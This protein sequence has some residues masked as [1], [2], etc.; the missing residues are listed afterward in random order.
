[1]N[2]TYV[3]ISGEQTACKYLIKKGYK[4]IST[5]ARIA[6]VEVDIVS[7]CP[8]KLLLK[9]LKA[10]YKSGK[11]LKTSYLAE[12]KNLQDTLVF[13]EVKARS[14]ESYGMPAEAVNWHKQN[15]IRRFA[16]TFI[17]SNKKYQN[18]P[19]RFDIISVL[20][21]QIEHIENAF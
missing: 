12:R 8:K 20:N 1:M 17:A 19:A 11:L 5:N 18:I 16:E 6:H 3:W 4:I 13:V 7:L 14:S 15:R 21:E 10:D 9:Q 2:N